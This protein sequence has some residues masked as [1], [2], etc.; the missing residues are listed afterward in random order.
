MLVGISRDRGSRHTR[1]FLSPIIR[2]DS[3]QSA[4]VIQVLASSYFIASDSHNSASDFIALSRRINFIEPLLA[5][6]DSSRTE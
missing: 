5:K 1:V 6:R 3:S 4:Y 2:R